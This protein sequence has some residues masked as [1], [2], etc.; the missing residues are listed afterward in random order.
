MSQEH[1]AH[2][3]NIISVILF[4]IAH[5][6]PIENDYQQ[7]FYFLYYVFELLASIQ[8]IQV[9]YISKM[10]LKNTLYRC[11]FFPDYSIIKV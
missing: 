10:S 7:H 9:F 2:F 6:N 1:L 5:G 4:S 8:L 3:D 11:S